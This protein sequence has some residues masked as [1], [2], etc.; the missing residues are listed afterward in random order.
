MDKPIHDPDSEL[1][2]IGWMLA[3]PN[4]WHA[5]TDEVRPED[6]YNPALA[7]AFV[8]LVSDGHQTPQELADRSGVEVTILRTWMM[9][10]HLDLGLT[11]TR[12]LAVRVARLAVRRRLNRDLTLSLAENNDPELSEE[13]VVARTRERID[14]AIVPDAPPEV[15]SKPIGQFMREVNMEYD[16][17]IDG[18]LERHDRMIITAHGGVGKSTLLRQF[19]L[20]SAAGIHPFTGAAMTPRRVLLLDLENSD[21]QVARALRG[22]L[23]KAGPFDENNLHIIANPTVVDITTS[24]GWRWLSSH[25]AAVH[26]DLICVGPVYRMYTSGDASKDMGGRDKAV[27]VARSL[28]DLR[29]KYNCAIIGEAHPPKGAEHLAPWG[30]MVWTAWPEFGV[31]LQPCEPD[32]PTSV[33]W[34]HWRGPRDKRDWPSTL[35]RGGAFGWKTR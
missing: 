34:K 26:P 24:G 6:F 9:N 8:S 32:N 2:L 3:K 28:D 25:V 33:Y 11:D 21:R 13:E 17:L 30:S 10:S 12:R 16:W 29:I 1:H 19:A 7:R 27:Q 15:P 35:H 20:C 31:G 18:L 14:Q 23:D 22:P 5:V 4:H